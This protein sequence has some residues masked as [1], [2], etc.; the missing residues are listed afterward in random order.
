MPVQPSRHADSIGVVI[1]LAFIGGC[2]ALLG[3]VADAGFADGVGDAVARAWPYVVAAL[4]LW[5]I[6]AAA[7]LGAHLLVSRETLPVWLLLGR[8]VA[9]AAVALVALGAAL[10]V[11]ELAGVTDGFLSVVAVLAA[12]ARLSAGPVGRLLHPTGNA[13][14]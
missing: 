3:A 11:L 5:A 9:A 12:W 2:L 8:A 7:E 10:G 13:R 14:R 6:A 1:V 4:V